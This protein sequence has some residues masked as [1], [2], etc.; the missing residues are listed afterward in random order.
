MALFELSPAS[1]RAEI[2]P[3][4][5]HIRF[6]L[7]IVLSAVLKIAGLLTIVSMLLTPACCKANL[8]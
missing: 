5:L 7:P 8:A 6:I 3:P 1:T 2:V 4:D